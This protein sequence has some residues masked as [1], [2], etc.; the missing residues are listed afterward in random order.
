MPL[1]IVLGS[2]T[3]FLQQCIKFWVK[4]NITL[5]SQCTGL[6]QTC[7][8]KR[9]ETK[10]GTENAFN[11]DHFGFGG[12]NKLECDERT[13]FWV[14]L[15]NLDL[16]FSIRIHLNVELFNNCFFWDFEWNTWIRVIHSMGCQ[17]IL[18]SWEYQRVD[19]RDYGDNEM[20]ELIRLLG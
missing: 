14:T 5:G 1:F 6:L 13:L 16:N 7:T 18:N 20:T 3:P 9:V 11:W 17:R 10:L 15:Q 8:A 4:W 12:S 2:R 19:F